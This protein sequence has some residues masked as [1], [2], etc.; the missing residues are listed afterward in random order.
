MFVLRV[1]SW[2]LRIRRELEDEAWITSY[3]DG[4]GLEDKAGR[5]YTRECHLGF[6]EDK[7]ESEYLGT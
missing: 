2:E 6:H 4:T 7:A 1:P 5:A 3:T